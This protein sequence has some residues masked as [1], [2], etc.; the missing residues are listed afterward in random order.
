MLKSEVYI[1]CSYPILCLKYINCYHKIVILCSMKCQYYS[2]YT[3][4]TTI[5]SE[6]Y[7]ACSYPILCLKYIN[8]YHKIENFSSVAMP[9]L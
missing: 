1:A 2:K 5:K 3:L 4:I 6:V 9:R 7:I 8:C